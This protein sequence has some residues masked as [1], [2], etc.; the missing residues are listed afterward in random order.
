M[1]DKQKWDWGSQSLHSLAHSTSKI[2][3]RDHQG[4][5]HAL[6]MWYIILNNW[7]ECCN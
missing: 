1:Q 5:E 6:I 4:W 7:Y 2:N 3:K